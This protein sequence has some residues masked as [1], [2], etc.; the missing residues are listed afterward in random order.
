MRHCYG[1]EKRSWGRQAHYGAGYK[2]AQHINDDG[3]THQVGL[4]TQGNGATGLHNTGL[5]TS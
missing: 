5:E 2:R 4:G 1:K 3:D